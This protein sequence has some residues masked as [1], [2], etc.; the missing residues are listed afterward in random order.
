[1]TIDERLEALTM[2]LELTAAQTHELTD[3]MRELTD[4][5]KEIKGSVLTLVGSMSHMA[6][7]MARMA[8]AVTG[9]EQR[10]QKLEGGRA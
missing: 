9:H 7:A 6:E 2:N 1:M 3:K 8:D 5:V 10:I 4:S